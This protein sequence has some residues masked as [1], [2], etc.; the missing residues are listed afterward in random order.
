MQ[1]TRIFDDLLIR[2]ARQW[3]TKCGLIALLISFGWLIGLLQVVCNLLI[4]AFG[5]TQG[6]KVFWRF[7][8][9]LDPIRA[10]AR[11]EFGVMRSTPVESMAEW[12]KELETMD[13][14]GA[15]PVLKMYA[16]I[17]K[18]QDRTSKREIVSACLEAEEQSLQQQLAPVRDAGEMCCLLGLTGSLLGILQAVSSGGGVEAIEQSMGVMA[19]TSAM[20]ACLAIILMGLS[21]LGSSAIDRHIAELRLAA[22]LMPGGEVGKSSGEDFISLF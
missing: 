17:S 20:G 15:G 5:I 18:N 4:L 13:L 16:A 6:A 3:Q 7:A 2:E 14:R 9:K 22:N 8:K 10:V 11:E 21:T 12:D 19:S 1:A